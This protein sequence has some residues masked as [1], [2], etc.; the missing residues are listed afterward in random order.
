MKEPLFFLSNNACTVKLEKRKVYQA[1]ITMCDLCFSDQRKRENNRAL[2]NR[3]MLEDFPKTV[4]AI[5]I[6]N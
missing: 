6:N 4:K 5:A 2:D 1:A 3:A